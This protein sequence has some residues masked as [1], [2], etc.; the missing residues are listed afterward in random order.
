MPF[1]SRPNTYV[2]E[3]GLGVRLL[4]YRGVARRAVLE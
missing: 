1:T 2:Y 4:T 3:V